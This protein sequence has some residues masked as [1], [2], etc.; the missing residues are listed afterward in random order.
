MRSRIVRQRDRK[1][2]LIS[3]SSDGGRKE[4]GVRND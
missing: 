3:N 1:L 4:V 2:T